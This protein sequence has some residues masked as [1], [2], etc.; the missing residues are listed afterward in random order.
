MF[1]LL[2]K[3]GLG[4]LREEWKIPAVTA[5]VTVGLGGCHLIK[6]C[7][8][9][10]TPSQIPCLGTSCQPATTV[11]LNWCVGMPRGLQS[12]LQHPGCK[13]NAG[14]AG[15]GEERAGNTGCTQMLMPQPCSQWE[16]E[17]AL[18]P[19]QPGRGGR[20]APTLPG[21][22]P[23]GLTFPQALE[24]KLQTLC[25]KGEIGQ[26]GRTCDTLPIP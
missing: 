8:L 6:P 5:A 20:E 2:G 24:T 1:R 14:F 25:S 26:P 4:L 3:E 17:A 9:Y 13:R 22:T 21:R 19:V 11:G 7:L 12:L 23:H 10:M 16:L 15:E 18:A